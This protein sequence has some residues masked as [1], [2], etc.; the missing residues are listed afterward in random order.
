MGPWDYNIER[1]IHW[2]L[3]CG[4]AYDRVKRGDSV[5]TTEILIVRRL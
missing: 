1:N 2:L 5:K 4:L 3:L